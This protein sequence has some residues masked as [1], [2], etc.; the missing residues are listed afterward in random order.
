MDLHRSLN[1]LR[2]S[3][4]ACGVALLAAC[5]G[6]GGDSVLAT[7]RSAPTWAP[8]IGQGDGFGVSPDGTVITGTTGANS[9]SWTW[10]FHRQ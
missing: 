1:V 3:V 6:G 8:A 10:T 2:Q 5:G 4:W 7:C 9:T